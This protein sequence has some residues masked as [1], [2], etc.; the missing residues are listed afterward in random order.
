MD[1]SEVPARFKKN[2]SCQTSVFAFGGQNYTMKRWKGSNW[3]NTLISRHHVTCPRRTSLRMNTDPAVLTG[4]WGGLDREAH[5]C[6]VGYSH[7][8]SPGLASRLGLCPVSL[9]AAEVNRYFRW[10]IGGFASNERR[11]RP[12]A[13]WFRDREHSP[14]GII[15]IFVE[16]NLIHNLPSCYTLPSASWLIRVQWNE[17]MGII[18]FYFILFFYL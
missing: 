1:F 10:L 9:E 6:R 13:H 4:R 17:E 7:L 15:I 14:N 3:S 8:F 18:L 11:T 16:I 12:G 2:K 5:W